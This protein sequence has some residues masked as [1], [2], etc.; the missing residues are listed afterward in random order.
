MARFNANKSE[1]YLL[2]FDGIF[3]K[4]IMYIDLDSFLLSC[5]V[6]SLS[7]AFLFSF[8]FMNIC[9]VLSWCD[10]YMA[11]IPLILGFNTFASF[12]ANLTA[13]QTGSISLQNLERSFFKN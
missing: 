13:F 3:V 12:L 7:I 4:A 6:S 1:I 10:L 11:T 2:I 8:F 5:V 9:V